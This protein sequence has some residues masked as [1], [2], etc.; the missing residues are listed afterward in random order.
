MFVSKALVKR[1]LL[2]T[3]R[4]FVTRFQQ[5]LFRTGAHLAGLG[6]VRVRRR[7]ADDA[8]GRKGIDTLTQRLL[9]RR[10]R[11]LLGS[12]S[13]RCAVPATWPTT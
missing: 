8:A 5:R 12:D 9:K 4:L 2:C 10:V 7:G 6:L 1:A 3:A 11:T 13:S